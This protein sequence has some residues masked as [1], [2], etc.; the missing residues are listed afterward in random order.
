MENSLFQGVM[1]SPWSSRWGGLSQDASSSVPEAVLG[2]CI[3]GSPR[4][5]QGGM[6]RSSVGCKST[7]FASP[8]LGVWVLLQGGG[9]PWRL[10]VP[11][12]VVG[13]R[14]SR[15]KGCRRPGIKLKGKSCLQA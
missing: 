9:Q 5:A 10:R 3:P 11:R 1:P 2:F 14:G 13:C 12:S 15:A 6:Q 8:Q 4:A 7:L